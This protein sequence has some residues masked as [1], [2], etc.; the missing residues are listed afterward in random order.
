LPSLQ[1][2]NRIA[3]FEWLALSFER[4][5]FDTVPVPPGSTLMVSGH[6]PPDYHPATIPRHFSRP[7]LRT[8]LPPNITLCHS[9]FSDRRQFLLRAATLI[10]FEIWEVV[11]PGQKLSSFPGKFLKKLFLGNLTQKTF[12]PGI[13]KKIR[14]FQAISQKIN[15]PGKNW[16]FTA[17]PRL[18]ILF[19]FNSHHFRTYFLYMIRGNNISRPVHDL[20]ANPCDPPTTPCP[21]SGGRDPP[22]S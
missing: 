11:D 9:I 4:A 21:K 1:Q 2:L 8:I 7:L 10:W 6:Y 13:F 19:L 16:P 12:F 22:T 15:F 17:T 20:P 18:I 3:P 5:A 14:F